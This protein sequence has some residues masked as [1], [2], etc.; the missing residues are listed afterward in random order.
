MLFRSRQAR[1]PVAGPK[2]KRWAQEV[3]TAC[4]EKDPTEFFRKFSELEKR[5]F[6]LW[7]DTFDLEFRKVGEGQWIFQ[8]EN[9]G[10]LSKV[11]KVYELT[12]DKN[13]YT[14]TLTETRVPT[15]GSDEK[16]NQTVWSFDGFSE[17][18]LPCDFVSHNNVQA[19]F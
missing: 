11:V 19:R 1:S 18:E 2:R 13:G 4:S 6:D 17:F 10:L 8:Q 16:P 9:P 5:T 14:W 3:A 15:K 12:E 7:V